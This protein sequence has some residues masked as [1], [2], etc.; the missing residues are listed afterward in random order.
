M[1]SPGIPARA[2]F[3]PPT[4]CPPPPNAGGQL[5]KE[6]T[7]GGGG[8]GVQANAHWDSENRGPNDG[9]CGLKAGPGYNEDARRRRGVGV[10]GHTEGEGK[11]EE[12]ADAEGRGLDKRYSVAPQNGMQNIFYYYYLFRYFYIFLLLLF[13]YL[14]ILLL[15][16]LILAWVREDMSGGSGVG[17]WKRT[18]D[19][20]FWNPTLFFR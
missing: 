4:H 5:R 14:F 17:D 12:G 9:S 13:I 19:E 11:P 20:T 1:V 2:W 6:K 10:R 18:W 15:K 16:I 3:H 7:S 8:G